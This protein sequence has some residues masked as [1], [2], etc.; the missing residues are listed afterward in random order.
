MR[1]INK[2]I[3]HFILLFFISTPY[4]VFA[5]DIPRSHSRDHHIELVKRTNNIVLAKAIFTKN[6]TKPTF[7]VLEVIKGKVGKNISLPRG[8]IV[9][10]ETK[11]AHYYSN[12]GVAVDFEGHT[13]LLFWDKFAARPGLGSDCM[14]RPSFMVGKTYLLFLGN[15]DLRGY[16]EI[17][18]DDDLWLLAVRKLVR[19]PKLASGLS[20]TIKEWLEMSNNAFI[21]VANDCQGNGFTVKRTLKGKLP[22]IWNTSQ[23]ESK[24]PL[25]PSSDYRCLKGAEFLIISYID[26]FTY[27]GSRLATQV[28]ITDNEASLVQDL[29]NSQIQIIGTKILKFK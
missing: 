1:Y 13:N 7:E 8:R 15:Q 25:K 14:I 26:G 4:L 6:S 17:I 28:R 23:N 16:E 19:N 24:Q 29:Q 21:G 5:C 3:Y 27:F 20:I 22:L 2:I 9:S 12:K 18:V 11:A 10:D